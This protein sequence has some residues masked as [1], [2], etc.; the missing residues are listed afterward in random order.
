MRWWRPLHARFCL[1]AKARVRAVDQRGSAGSTVIA[2]AG[3]PATATG[4]SV[5]APQGDAMAVEDGT[6]DQMAIS[7][8]S[9]PAVR[10]ASAQSAPGTPYQ[11]DIALVRDAGGRT[12]IGDQYVAYP[13][14]LC[15]ALRTLG[16]P[17]DMPTLYIQSCSGGLF[18]GDD[19]RCRFRVGRGARV[20][21]TSAAATI[22]HTM[23]AGV[24]ALR[25]EIDA[26]TG[27]YVEYLPD[28]LILFPGAAMLNWVRIRLAGDATV[29]AWDSFLSHDPTGEGRIFR[30]LTSELSIVDDA[31]RLLARDRY[32]AEGAVFMSAAPGVM[33][34]HRTQAGFVLARR[35][36]PVQAW[37]A[38]LREVL[39]AAEDAYVGLSALPNGVGVWVRVLAPDAAQSSKVLA[40][41]W[42]RAREMITG[43]IPMPRRK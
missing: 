4:E 32:R 41:M 33:G 9:S 21:L 26:A 38:G 24:G 28:P 27:A 22:V 19:L 40:K 15:R 39:P 1:T 20:H 29:L 37:L 2:G 34:A 13:F 10:R 16:D 42:A 5:A 31:G 43:S 14:H 12:H 3:D 17:I 30:R 11:L 18:E 7:R 25:V 36:A 6:A 8:H 23:E 35:D